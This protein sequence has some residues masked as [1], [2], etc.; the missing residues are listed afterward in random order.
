MATYYNRYRKFT[1]NGETV[2]I[3]PNINIP[4]KNT[5]ET[6]IWKKGTMRIDRISSRYYGTPYGG[7]IILIKN[8]FFDENEIEDNTQLRIPF[9]FNSSVQSYIDQVNRY[10]LLYGLNDNF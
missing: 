1:F 9:P 7:W 4:N 2:K 6:I 10:E 8:G 3:V 5:D